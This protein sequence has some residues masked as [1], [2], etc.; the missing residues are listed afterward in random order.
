M[1]A[2]QSL[3]KV[4]KTQTVDTWFNKPGKVTAGIGT[5]VHSERT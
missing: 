5:V 1:P 3:A 2:A 4:F